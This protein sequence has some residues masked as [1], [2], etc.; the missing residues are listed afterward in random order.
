M[1]LKITFIVLSE[2]LIWELGFLNDILEKRMWEAEKESR[3]GVK[4]EC[5]TGGSGMCKVLRLE[6]A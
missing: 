6:S 2:Y 3:V 5:R 4:D 1:V